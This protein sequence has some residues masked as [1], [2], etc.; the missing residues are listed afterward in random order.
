VGNPLKEGDDDHVHQQKLLIRDHVLADNCELGHRMFDWYFPDAEFHLIVD[1][2]ENLLGAHIIAL[3]INISGG[4]VDKMLTKSVVYEVANELEGKIDT[5]VLFEVLDLS[6]CHFG[7]GRRQ[8]LRRGPVRWDWSAPVVG[9][10][11]AE[12]G[13][14]ASLCSSPPRAHGCLRQR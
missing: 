8:A 12:P 5:D 10:S 1:L 11:P 9:C 2:K 6:I 3:G 4:N 13:W 14:V 7:T